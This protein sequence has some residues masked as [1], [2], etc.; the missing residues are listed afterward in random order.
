MSSTSDFNKVE[1]LID[2]MYD[3]GGRYPYDA[4]FEEMVEILYDEFDGLRMTDNIYDLQNEVDLAA[5]ATD[6]IR[7]KGLQSMAR[8]YIMQ[9]GDIASK[10]H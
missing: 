10:Y 9:I 7:D 8:E 3:E 4:A 5:D 1:Q 6:Y 2:K